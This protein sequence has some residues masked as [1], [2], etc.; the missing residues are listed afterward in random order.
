MI[1]PSA[2]TV[3][4]WMGYHQPGAFEMEAPEE[5][6]W[7]KDKEHMWQP[8]TTT[9]SRR[10][11]SCHHHFR[12]Y[13]NQHSSIGYANGTGIFDDADNSQAEILGPYQ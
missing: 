4:F 1:T 6:T 12:L 13:S 10:L 7:E 11:L 8:Q 9:W 3:F 5:K 2:P